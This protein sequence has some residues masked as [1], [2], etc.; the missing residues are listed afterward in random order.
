MVLE[1]SFDSG[2]KKQLLRRYISSMKFRLSLLGFF[3]FIAGWSSAQNIAQVDL[4]ALS[5]LDALVAENDDPKSL[6]Q[7]TGAYPVA[8]V[9]GQATV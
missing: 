9:H 2:I 8:E 1:N 7:V 3:V 6:L 4:Q 5:E